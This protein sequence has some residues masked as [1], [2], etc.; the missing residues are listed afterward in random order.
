[1]SKYACIGKQLTDFATRQNKTA[2]I[3]LLAVFLCYN[4]RV[5]RV[6]IETGN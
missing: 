3:K 4:E 5:A 6:A 2:I 1:M